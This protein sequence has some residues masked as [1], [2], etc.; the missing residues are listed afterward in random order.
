ML[1]TYAILAVIVPMVVARAVLRKRIAKTKR[2]EI[3]EGSCQQAPETIGKPSA[4]LKEHPEV[5]ALAQVYMST[6]VVGAALLE[7]AAMAATV[8]FLL[9]QAG[10]ML[11]VIALLIAGVGA[12]F[13]T[14]GQVVNWIE[15]ELEKVQQQRELQT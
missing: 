12:H 9:E 1:L 13:P 7:G 5:A 14:L 10:P 3:A 8:A 15:R 11:I 4:V 6:T 2:K